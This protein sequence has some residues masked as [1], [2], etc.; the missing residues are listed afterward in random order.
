MVMAI[1]LII[2]ATI[3]VLGPIARAIA[4][5]IAHEQP[6]DAVAGRSEMARLK[7][8]VDRLSGEVARLQE[9]QSFMVR[10]LNDGE[11]NRLGEARQNVE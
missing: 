5:R 1:L 8:E 4:E 2:F 3:F 11:R 6:P 7:E 9:E 10:L